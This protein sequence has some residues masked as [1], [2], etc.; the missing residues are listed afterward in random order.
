[1]NR[2]SLILISVLTV[3]A[4]FT[5]VQFSESPPPRSIQL[6]TG[7]E[8]GAYHQFGLQLADYLRRSGLQ[9][10]V[11]PTAGALENAAL[12]ESGGGTTIGFVQAGLVSQDDTPTLRGIAGLYYEPLWVFYRRDRF[13]P[14]ETADADPAPPLP[15][16]VTA[17][18]H[19]RIAIGEP[20]SGTLAMAEQI[21]RSAGISTDLAPQALEMEFLRL[22]SSAAAEQLQNAEINAAIFVAGPDSPLIDR[23]LHDPNL[24]LLSF[25]RDAAFVREL[26]FLHSLDIPA[27]LIDLAANVPPR[28][29]TLLAPMAC[30]AGHA[31]THPA[32]TERI[33]LAAG[34]VCK[35][36]QLLTSS[37]VFPALPELSGVPV[38]PTA[39][40]VISSGASAMSQ[41]LPY[42]MLNLIRQIRL[43]VI[44]FI[45]VLL[46]VTRGIPLLLDFRTSRRVYGYYRRLYQLEHERAAAD[47]LMAIS[48]LQQLRDDVARMSVPLRYQKD[49]YNLRLHILLVLSEL[50]GTALVL[51]SDA[52]DSEGSSSPLPD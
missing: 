1:M 3:V 27:G 52:R 50:R 37:T 36:Q 51:N 43:L 31:E 42:W 20:G 5:L 21:F 32:V 47:R 24:E 8:Q 7:D 11:T 25:R 29:T 9:V 40:R 14:P 35:S 16:D 28:Q 41:L 10:I 19:C 45:P 48:E 38:D 26:D 2:K 49:V 46:F 15:D 39:E 17:L 12:I 23:L 33:L 22:P 4:A 18:S 13:L 44:S 34:E 6:V 30:L